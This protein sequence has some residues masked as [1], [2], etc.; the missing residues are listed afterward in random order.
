MNIQHQV[1]GNMQSECVDLEVSC[2]FNFFLFLV[3][4]ARVRLFS[5]HYYLVKVLKQLLYFE[6]LWSVFSQTT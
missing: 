1:R 3:L 2:I 6:L 4:V 5:L